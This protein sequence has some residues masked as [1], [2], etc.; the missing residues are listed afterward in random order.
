MSQYIH[1]EKS[2]NRKLLR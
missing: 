2:F 1:H